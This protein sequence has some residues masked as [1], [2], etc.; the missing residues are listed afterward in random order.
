MEEVKGGGR[1]WWTNRRKDRR[2]SESRCGRE[3]K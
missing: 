3:R 1:K 2:D